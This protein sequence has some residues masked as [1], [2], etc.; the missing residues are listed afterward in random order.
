V[1]QKFRS[2][3]GNIRSPIST[4]GSARDHQTEGK[5]VAD[6][7]LTDAQNSNR[8]EGATSCAFRFARVTVWSQS[9]Q[10]RIAA[11]TSN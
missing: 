3:R 6:K 10:G 7:A 5:H 11:R 8:L 2:Q 4:T 1:F 9:K